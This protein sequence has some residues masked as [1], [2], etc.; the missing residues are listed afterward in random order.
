MHKTLEEIKQLEAERLLARNKAIQTSKRFRIITKVYYAT[1]AEYKD[2]MTAY[3]KLDREY[4]FAVFD[5]KQ[6][7]K[8]AKKSKPYDSAKRTAEKALLALKSL[9]KEMRD[10]VLA[11]AQNGLF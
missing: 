6:V 4:A 1:E 2:Q 10:K 8:Q 3:N 9:P 5:N 7:K 11:N